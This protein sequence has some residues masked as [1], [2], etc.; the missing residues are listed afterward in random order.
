MK[1]L[2]LL[3]S[4]LFIAQAADKKGLPNQAGNDD[5]ELAGTIIL[6]RPEIQT[7]LGADLGA[8]YAVVQIK[9]TPK[10]ERP[11]QISADDFSLLSR[12]DGEK[13]PALSP[14]QIAGRGAMV[15]KQGR[16]LTGLGTQSNGPIWGGIGP[17]QPRKLP[18]NGG[19][20]GGGPVESG[21]AEAS[22][23]KESHAGEN[24]L[25]QPLKAKGLA[26]AET[27]KPVEGLLYFALEGKNK[28]KDLSLLY[29]GPAGRLVFDFK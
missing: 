15:V 9:V 26:D 22:I 25:L 17:A 14:S 19:S 11:I 12:K 16:Q 21:K 24:P 27:N 6:D 20:A 8:G 3:V 23:D 18:G 29:K 13:S 10:A 1:T 7:L 5:I 28:P 2:A 4:L